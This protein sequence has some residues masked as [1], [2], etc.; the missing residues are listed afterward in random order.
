VDRRDRVSR[1]RDEEQEFHVRWR[2]GCRLGAAILVD[3][4]TGSKRAPFPG[5]C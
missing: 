2:T 4:Q 1:E 3:A 5:R